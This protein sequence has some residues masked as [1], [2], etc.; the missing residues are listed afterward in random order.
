MEEKSKSKWLQEGDANTRFFHLST[1]NHRRVNNID[2]I[3]NSEGDW[4]TDREGIRNAFTDFYSQLFSFCSPE[5][6]NYLE[7]LI[8]ASIYKSQNSILCEVP[9]REEIRGV[10]FSFKNGKSHGLDGMTPS[11]YKSYWHTIRASVI[12]AV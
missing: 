8:S 3:L 5:Y 4:I 11:F 7:N 1:I 2:P 9:S 10:V 12:K 6:L